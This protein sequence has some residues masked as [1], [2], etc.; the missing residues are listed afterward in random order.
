MLNK[1]TVL[2][3][4]IGLVG[5]AW[6]QYSL[7]NNAYNA[8][9]EACRASYQEKVLEQQLMQQKKE[10]AFNERI[11]AL[12]I[13]LTE[14]RLTYEN[15][16]TKLKSDYANELL[17]SEKRA[18]LYLSYA[19]SDRAKQRDLAIHTAK[20]DRSLTEG[21]ELVKQ[22]TETIR[23]RDA[24]LR[25]LGVYIQESTNLYEREVNRLEE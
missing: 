10:R 7:F 20:L 12:S 15:T 1:L 23:T 11:E 9:Y 18:E 16:V 4:I 13:E 5:I 8:G 6:F 2:T 14:T 3:G 19:K 17:N 21:R 25:A 24:Q 22:L